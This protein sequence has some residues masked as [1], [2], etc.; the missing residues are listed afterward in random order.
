MTT[1][2]TRTTKCAYCDDRATRKV[3]RSERDC[4]DRLTVKVCADCCASMAE[5]GLLQ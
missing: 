1:T 4:W 3:Q 2:R 5:N